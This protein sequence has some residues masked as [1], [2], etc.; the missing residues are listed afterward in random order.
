[1]PKASKIDESSILE[2]CEAAQREKKPNISKI[3]RE[4]SISYDILRGRV[5]QGKQARSARIPINKTLNEY[6]KEALI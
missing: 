6:Q 5:R 1:M 2:A 4:Y 3:A